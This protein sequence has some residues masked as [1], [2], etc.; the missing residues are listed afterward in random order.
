MPCLLWSSS[1]QFEP[2][3]K[4]RRWIN[5]SL[6]KYMPLL[7]VF[8]ISISTL[9]GVFQ[10]YTKT[11]QL[12]IHSLCFSDTEIIFSNLLWQKI[13]ALLLSIPILQTRVILGFFV[14]YGFFKNF[15]T[16][17]GKQFFLKMFV[18]FIFLYKKTNKQLLNCIKRKFYLSQKLYKMNL[19]CCMME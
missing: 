10:A 14:F 13:A 2:L 3:E 11:Q 9:K 7:A 19:Q 4:I 12:Q 5:K 16:K 1:P 17:T 8:P 6:E 18:I 15:S